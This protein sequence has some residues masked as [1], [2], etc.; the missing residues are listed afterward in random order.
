[1]CE[2]K[3][4]VV[5]C[6]FFICNF[7]FTLFSLKFGLVWYGWGYALASIVSFALAFILVAKHIQRLPYET[8]VVKNASV[9]LY[10]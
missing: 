10:R 9:A 3:V 5:S 2:K 7:L 1:M 4:M 8:F 6:T